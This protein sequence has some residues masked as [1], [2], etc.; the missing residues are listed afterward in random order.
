MRSAA[1]SHFVSEAAEGASS[2]YT[3]KR[4]DLGAAKAVA[5]QPHKSQ[6]SHLCSM[7]LH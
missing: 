3:L 4:E 7:L 5:A 6:R 2:I 1:R